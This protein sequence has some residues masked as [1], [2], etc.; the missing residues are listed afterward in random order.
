MAEIR[1]YVEQKPHYTI[2]IHAI[3]QSDRQSSRC[4]FGLQ[5]E[6]SS[7]N[8]TLPASESWSLKATEYAGRH[9]SDIQESCMRFAIVGYGKSGRA[10]GRLIQALPGASVSCVIDSDLGRAEAGARALNASAWSDNAD[11]ALRC[12]SVDAVVG[13]TPH[14]YHAQLARDTLERGLPILLEAPL[15]L[16]HPD[17]QQVLGY[18]RTAGTV[19]AVNFWLRATPEVRLIRRRIPR[20]TFVQVKS[21]VDPLSESWMGS[22]RHGGVMGLLGSHALDLASFL[23][24]SQPRYI[25]AMGGRHT[26]RADLAD[27]AVMGI[28]YANGGLARVI[29]GEYGRSQASAPWHVLATD[30]TVT[31]TAQGDVPRGK[32]RTSGLPGADV[33]RSQSAC[34]GRAT[35]L[36]AFAD[37]V[38]GRGRPLAGVDDGVRAVQLADAAYEA[39]RSRR[40][41]PIAAMSLPDAVGPVYADD[42]VPHRRHHSFRA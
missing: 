8:V 35:S 28:R 26:R 17:A 11:V 42:S 13:A 20:P 18:A 21:V 33:S 7:P 37:A 22:A 9:G 19:V 15:A 38:A 36:Q 27:T 41:V 14:A 30:G 6:G 40:R 23:M 3:G 25:Q 29:V 24:Q 16:R 34:A 4:W 2:A 32:P 1:R 12:A 10:F 39:M 5:S 31:A